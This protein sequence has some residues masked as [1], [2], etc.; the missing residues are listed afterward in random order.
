MQRKLYS[1]ILWETTVRSMVAGKDNRVGRQHTL[2]GS[3][4]AMAVRSTMIRQK[5][6][7]SKPFEYTTWKAAPRQ[8]DSLVD[9]VTE[10]KT[11]HLT[12][13]RWGF[14]PLRR[15]GIAIGRHPSERPSSTAPVPAVERANAFLLSTCTI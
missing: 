10:R 7:H 8:Y 2:P 6:I 12:V 3:M 11:Q 9:R 14:L 4:E 13:P 5:T 1:I 15:M